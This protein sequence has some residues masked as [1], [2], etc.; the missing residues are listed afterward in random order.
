[1]Q[2]VHK[3]EFDRV[4]CCL[5]YC[6]CVCIRAFFCRI[7]QYFFFVCFSFV[8]GFGWTLLQLNAIKFA[9]V[10]QLVKKFEIAI[11]IG[12]KIERNLRLNS[13]HGNDRYAI[14]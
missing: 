11:I 7:F 8:N 4:S 13:I 2:T 6:D 9:C 10:C 1:M 12:N 3:T 14:I 5:V